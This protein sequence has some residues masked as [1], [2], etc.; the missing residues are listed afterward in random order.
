MKVSNGFLNQLTVNL[1]INSDENFSLI[2]IINV[3]NYNRDIPEQVFR[4]M[5]LR[6]LGVSAG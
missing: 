6:K 5:V 3:P 1:A 4:F 2:N